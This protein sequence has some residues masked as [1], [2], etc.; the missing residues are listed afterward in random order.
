[1]STTNKPPIVIT[2]AARRLGLALTQHLL[3]RGE[4]LIISYRTRYPVV[5]ILQQ[6]GALCLH[7]DFS[8]D[9]GI[10]TFAE[11]IRQ[12]TSHIRALIHNASNWQAE[13]P[14]EANSQLL[15]KLLQIHVYTPYLLNLA[16]EPLLRGHSVAGTDIIHITD[17]VAERG[18]ARHI[19]YAA[20]KAAMDNLTRSFARKLAPEV[21]VN[22]IAPSLILFHEQDG[23]DYRQQA[24]DKSLLKIEPTEQELVTLVDYLLT[25]RYI[26]GRTVP[27]DGGRHLR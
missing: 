27:L 22:S 26:T 4:R 7:A 3:A 15:A 17:F 5:D 12:H 19:A 24:L 13:Q 20:S 2:G 9:Q 11:N 18:S 1:M 23:A 25:S 10:L 8:T 14:G 21:K 16:L 6:Q